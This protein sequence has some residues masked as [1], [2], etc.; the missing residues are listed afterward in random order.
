MYNYRLG[1]ALLVGVY[2][3]SPMMMD[4]WLDSQ[5]AWYR[6]FTIWLL[7]IAFYVWLN[8]ARGDDEL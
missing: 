2:F 7:L 1:L 3:F 8:H 6:P 5:S 4:W